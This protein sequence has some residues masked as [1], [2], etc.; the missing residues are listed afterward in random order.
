M[1]RKGMRAASRSRKP[2]MLVRPPLARS[3]ISLLLASKSEMGLARR[4]TGHVPNATAFH[5][6]IVQLAL[7]PKLIS[8]P[9]HVILPVEEV[10]ASAFQISL[11]CHPDCLGA[12]NDRRCPALICNCLQNPRLHSVPQAHSGPQFLMR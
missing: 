11:V 3:A 2:S 7:L 8:G 4:S 9:A 5:I 6:P 10:I 12:L 1:N